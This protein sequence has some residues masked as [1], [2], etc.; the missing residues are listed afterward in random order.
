[1]KKLYVQRYSDNQRITHWLV[2]VL[3]GMA[4][5]SGLALFHPN[6]FFLTQFFGGPQWTRIVHPYFGIA[7]FVLFLLMFLMFVG[8]N[9]WRRADTQWVKD[10]PK[11]VLDNDESKMPPVAK[12]NAGQKLVFWLMTLCLLVL[13]ATG[14]LFWQDWFATSV[15]I[16]VQRIAVVLHALAAFVMSLTA[17]VHIY[18]AIWVKGTL[19]AMTQGTVSAG[20]PSATTCCGIATRCGSRPTL[21]ADKARFVFCFYLYSF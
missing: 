12:Y 13:L 11:L 3:F 17:V 16:P 9:L 4:G 14:V 19:R 8:A 5:F 1:M 18:A 7:V 6:L 2:V 10:A 21:L 15:P 20:G